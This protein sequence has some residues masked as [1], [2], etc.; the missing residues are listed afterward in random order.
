M[1]IFR[2]HSR[3]KMI[4]ILL[5]IIACQL[6]VSAYFMAFEKKCYY[7]DDIYSYGASNSSEKLNPLQ[8]ELGI[9]EKANVNCWIDGETLADYLTVSKEDA[10]S[11]D[12]LKKTLVYDAHP[13]LYFIMLH[14]VCSFTPGV[15]S[16][17]SGFIINVAGFMIMQ[18]F[19][20][21]LTLLVS[22]DRS[23]S[24]IAVVFWGLTSATIN[25]MCFIRMYMLS[26]GITVAFTFYC[27]KCLFTHSEKKKIF[28]TSLSAA[29]VLL[30]LDSMTDYFSVI[31]AFFL[32]FFICIAFLLKKEIKKM[33]IFGFAMLCSVGLMFLTCPVLYSQL[34][35]DQP[36][37]R[38][39]ELY[40]YI[41]Q[42]RTG[43][44]V[45]MNSIFGIFTPV[46]ASMLPLYCLWT[47]CGIVIIYLMISFLFRKDEWFVQAKF[48]VKNG[49]K[50]LFIRSKGVLCRLLPVVL[51][52]TSL[53]LLYARKLL[54][55]FYHYQS[56][57]YLY[58]IGPYIA[59]T[60][61][62][63][64][65]GIIRSKYARVP[66]LIA[67]TALSLIFGDMC[68]LGKGRVTVDLP[69]AAKDADIVIV[70]KSVST[71]IFHV[72]DILGCSEYLYTTPVGLAE[73]DPE[74]LILNK[75]EDS[76]NM[77]LVVDIDCSTLDAKDVVSVDIS[78]GVSSY[79][80]DPFN[81]VFDLFKNRL[82][83][84]NAEYLG[85]YHSCYVY[86]LK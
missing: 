59:M 72:A 2:D 4:E 5:L 46:Y 61:I 64:V 30:Y 15:F 81:E 34:S 32:A 8:S 77:L 14:T 49:I 26:E 65:F 22:E 69:E 23:I 25:M 42:V 33:V 44:H 36:G 80:N 24:I 55:Y 9:G 58:I 18:L 70:E 75:A 83:F 76:D 50:N 12:N 21:R 13:P 66:V 28:F 78:S 35:F 53:F 38:R 37:L 1:D 29:F 10:F 19:L 86:R 39:A 43:I 68:F 40:P 41:L 63:V 67:M 51:A 85:M 48:K 3:K 27:L 73:G 71:F 60:V 7:A 11:Y 6:A 57:R 31:Y 62:V 84:S 16:R 56:I 45:L 74:K 82:G 20:Y 47:I 79:E 54:L 52:S 17:W